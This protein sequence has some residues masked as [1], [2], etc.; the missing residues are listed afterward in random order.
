MSL[1]AV[2]ATGLF[3]GGI[4]CAAVQ[5]GLLAGLVA[6]QSAG[7]PSSGVA[8]SAGTAPVDRR[9]A[10]ARAADDILP[11]GAFMLGKLVSHALLGALLGALGATVQMSP[12]A[13]VWTQLSAGVLIVAFGLAQL[14][15]GPFKRLTVTP[16]ASWARFVRGRA[17]S[18][19]ALAPAALGFLTV[20]VPC[21]VTLSVQA[22]ALA[23]GSIAL[24]AATMAVF[25]LGTGP[26]FAVLGYAARRTAAAWQGRLGAATGLVVL[27]M[28][29]YTVNG[30][31]T[32]ADSPLAVRNWPAMTDARTEPAGTTPA[33]AAPPVT[34]GSD[35]RQQIVV[36]AGRESYQPETLAARAGVPTTLVVR[37]KG[38][39]GCVRAF[40]IPSM[41][42]QWTLPVNGDVRID[43][44]VLP[45]G[46][47]LYSC[48][49]GMYSGQITAR[50]PQGS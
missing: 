43:L 33:A 6:R 39:R 21:G 7:S 17:R 46:D 13:R 1:S 26:L 23:S 35:G 8:Q 18:Q 19:A 25:V 20:L 5:G 3:A 24:G 42:R 37:A 29:L 12:A 45:V 14:G 9:N 11:V 22:L 16:P 49:M 47:L 15:V 34:I 36:V 44:G 41:N 38:A 48:A 40:V 32:L 30:A 2:L 4:S 27:A 50:D 10:R 28:G 31:L